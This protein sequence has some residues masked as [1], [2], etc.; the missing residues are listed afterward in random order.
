ML[1]VRLQ[2]TPD[3]PLEF[4]VVVKFDKSKLL[5]PLMQERY[6]L[7]SALADQL[8]IV[9]RAHDRASAEK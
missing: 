5:G 9:L 4:D 2:D 3:A 1:T 8:D 6:V 7:L